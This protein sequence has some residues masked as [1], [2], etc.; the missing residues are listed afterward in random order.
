L[1]ERVESLSGQG[2]KTQRPGGSG[3]LHFEHAVNVLDASAS[4]VG[5]DDFAR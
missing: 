4:A 2:C 5:R 1:Q 3:G